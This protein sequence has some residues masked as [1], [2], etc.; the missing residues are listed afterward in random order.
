M[1][2]VIFP[3]YSVV[4][5]L[6]SRHIN[7]Y[8]RFRHCTVFKQSSRNPNGPLLGYGPASSTRLLIALSTYHILVSLL[9]MLLRYILLVVFSSSYC[10]I[11]MSGV[12][13]M[14]HLATLSASLKSIW[15][16]APMTPYRVE[17][18]RWPSFFSFTT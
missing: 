11:H 7:A 15:S 14:I 16:G 8:P 17:L 12:L 1:D 4:G 2:H 10:C 13:Q 6:Q 9:L 5:S 3:T 18:R